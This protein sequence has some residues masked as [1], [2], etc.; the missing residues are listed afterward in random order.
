MEAE[1]IDKECD[2]CGNEGVV[3]VGMKVKKLIL[4][5][6]CVKDLHWTLTH[7]VCSFDV[8]D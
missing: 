3:S 4:C 6:G 1:R 2:G 8:D 7:D 5:K